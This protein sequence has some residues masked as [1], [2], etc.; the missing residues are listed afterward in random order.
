VSGLRW[1]GTVAHAIASRR[2]VVRA[3]GLNLAA[4]LTSG[5]A[6]FALAVLTTHV[7]DTHGRG[8][9]VVLTTAAGVGVVVLSAPAPVMVAD[10]VHD[11]HSE[12]ELRGGIV[13]LGAASAL[14]LALAAVIANLAGVHLPGP[15]WVQ[16]LAA[17]ATGV[18]V[19]VSC[20]I[21]LEQATGR[22]AGVSLGEIALA[23]LPLLASGV[24]AALG[25]ASL[26]SLITAWLV[27]VSATAALQIAFAVR[28]HAIVP[29][30]SAVVGRWLWRARSIAFSNGMLQLCARID[31][32]VVSAVISVSAAGVY[33]IPVA[34]AANLLLFP[35]A[36]LTATYRSIMTA[37]YELIARRTAATAAGSAA[38]VLIG[39][40]LG[41]PAAAAL[42]GP[43][44]GSAY[45]NIWI[46]L[47][48]LVPGIAAWSVV[49]VLRHV[50][51]TR[52]ER[53][54]E[55]LFT[56]LGMSVANGALAVVGSYEFGSTGAAASTTITYVAAALWMARVCSRQL[57]VPI[58]RM[59][60][61]ADRGLGGEGLD[62]NDGFLMRRIPPLIGERF[63]W[64]RADLESV[65]RL[66]LI[67]VIAAAVG[68]ACGLV[69]SLSQSTLYESRSQVVV[70]PASGFLDPAHSDAFPAISTSVQELALTERVL[71]DAASRLPG[72]KAEHT[73][74]WLRARLRLRIS[75]DTPV[76]TVDGV[77][78]DQKVASEVST[79]ETNALVDAVNTASTPPVNPSPAITPGTPQ[80][81]ATGLN[82]EVFSLGEPRGR[83]QPKTSR[84]VLLGASAGLII[85][86]FALAQLLSRTNRRRLA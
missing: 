45:G 31:V 58:R 4:R 53:Q 25:R 82:L 11:R 35:R 85:G 28:R 3:S 14:V 40:A 62:T 77:D 33:S 42:S 55:V 76:L 72:A 27:G 17:I 29:I 37:P 1:H 38:L 13:A 73:P 63:S 71:R 43:I 67:P 10:L 44:F 39:G 84:N 65:L 79:A 41:V 12:A 16:I 54:R 61:P 52:L 9:Y 83:I 32:L 36:L 86:C 78:G 51:L 60:V 24:V 46:P 50:L 19:F 20:E 47:A 6:A 66:A 26:G 74:D 15:A 80:A 48:V 2:Q 68:L 70:S 7:L 8:S 81:I 69:Y 22:V 75:G 49:E 34:L 56:A 59:F 57:G 5:A 30:D 21:G 64:S 23:T 18:V